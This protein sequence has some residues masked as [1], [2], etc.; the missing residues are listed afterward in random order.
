MSLATCLSPLSAASLPAPSP[1]VGTRSRDLKPPRGVYIPSGGI[2]NARFG[3]LAG[4]PSGRTAAQKL[5]LAYETRVNDVLSQ[6]Y[7][8]DYR[9]SASIL[10]QD[11]R[12]TH[13]CIPDGLLKIGS[14]LVIIEIKLRH[15]ERAWWQLSRLYLPVLTQ[16]VRPGTKIFR[17]EICRSY[18]PQEVFPDHDTVSS[19]HKLPL[20]RVGVLTWKI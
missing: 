14:D 20:N 8:I 18:D 12:G 17:A 1:A 15:T 2:F 6:I 11:R 13:R 16:L 7:G 3:G 10:F 19:L 5:G 9:H 4:P